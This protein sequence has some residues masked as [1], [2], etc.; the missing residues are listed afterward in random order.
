MKATEIV[1]NEL[2]A[3]AAE[4]NNT[5]TQKFT[6]IWLSWA[7]PPSEV[8]FDQAGAHRGAITDLCEQMNTLAVP[9]PAEAH[10]KLGFVER[11]V[12]V[13]KQMLAPALE[14]I[15]PETPEEF[16]VVLAA[17]N[18]AVN[19]LS[20]WDGYSPEQHVLGRAPRLPASLIAARYCERM[21]RRSSSRA[22]G[23]AGADKSIAA[24]CI[25]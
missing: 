12:G 14:Q 18:A 24:P 13:I 6:E 7:G 3:V 4:L 10:H 15:L 25:Q 8:E 9:I 5:M 20:R 23:S 2:M 19:R 16:G 21:I 11:R 17:Q 1:R 22:R